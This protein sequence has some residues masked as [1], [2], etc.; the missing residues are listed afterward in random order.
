MSDVRIAACVEGPTDFVVLDAIVQAVFGP[1]AQVTRL[2]PAMSRTPLG[3]ATAGEHGGGWKG[4]KAWCEKQARI[5]DAAFRTLLANNQAIVVHVDAD[6]AHETEI[7]CAEPCPP[8]RPTVDRLRE[9]L[10]G[11]LGIAAQKVVVLCVPA[12]AMDAWVAA[13]LHAKH[14]NV[15]T[16]HH[17]DPKRLLLERPKLVKSVDG[18]LKADRKKFEEQSNAIRDGWPEVVKTLPEAQRFDAELRAALA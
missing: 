8:A 5:G 14:R 4:V 13:A 7:N 3:G 6:I 18:S 16:E 12:Q 11:W 15:E 10:L 1:S 2:Q 17:D 9:V